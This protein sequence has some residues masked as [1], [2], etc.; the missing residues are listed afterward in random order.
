MKYKNTQT[1]FVSAASNGKAAVAVVARR[2]GDKMRLIGCLNYVR[3]G[4]WGERETYKTLFDAAA[5]KLGFVPDRRCNGG[6]RFN[7]V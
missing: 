3:C 5:K 1:R 4:A 7:G 2:D 6:Y